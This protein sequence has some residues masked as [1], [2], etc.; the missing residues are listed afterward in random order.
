[1]KKVGVE[2]DVLTTAQSEYLG[3]PKEGPYKPD[4]YRY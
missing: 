2:L 4:Y 3:L 1:L